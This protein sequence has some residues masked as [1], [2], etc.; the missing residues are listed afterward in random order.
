M[1]STGNLVLYKGKPCVVIDS[2]DRAEIRLPDGSTTRIR[3]K[4][5][6]LLH[7]GP[8][9][10]FDGNDIPQGDFETARQVS[11]GETVTLKELSELVFGEFLPRTAWAS[12]REILAGERFKLEDGAARA[13]T[14]EE[15]LAVRRKAAEKAEA[16][17][18]RA[19]FIA[20]G[21][22]FV[23][24]SGDAPFV[25]EI[26]AFALGSSKKGQLL[27]EIGFAET[28]EAAHEF[29]L[30]IG[31]WGEF[32][33]PHPARFGM[34]K[35]PPAV[36]IGPRDDE[37]RVD[38]TGL[39]SWAI[40]NAWTHDPDDAVAIEGK[41]LWI[42]AADPASS[43]AP[44]SPADL[45]ALARGATLYDPA[46]IVPMFPEA[47]LSSFCL[48]LTEISPALSFRVLLAN[49]GSIEET[50]ALRSWIKVRR[51]SYNEADLRLDREP[52]AALDAIA[53]RNEERRTAAGAVSIDIPEVRVFVVDGKPRIDPVPDT[54]SSSIV[55]EMMLIG[56]E[57]VARY[58]Y[59]AKL[60]IP[61]YSQESPLD[62]EEKPG[63]AGQ[64]ALRRTMR[65]GSVSAIPGPHRGLGLTFY[66]QAFS[67]LRRYPDLLAHQQIRSL[68]AGRE[69]LSADEIV[70]RVGAAQAAMSQVRQAERASN[71]HWTLAYLKSREGWTDTGVVVGANDRSASVYIPS[72]GLET[73]VRLPR[74]ELN[75]QIELQLTAIDLPKLEANFD[76]VGESR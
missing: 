30:R 43:V 39:D 76:V 37:G 70:R 28:P 55:R 66:S 74:A 69:P 68:L 47:A 9:K 19:E 58:S 20:R 32:Y 14:D 29:L 65:P 6:E 73:R 7:V 36:E 15:S 27:K 54:R 63:L 59:E 24:E 3:E 67:P 62:S 12:M 45:E 60:P 57:A 23:V 64:F 2:G 21:R 41:Y 44:E 72:I 75:D 17:K 35:R 61:Y 10:S 34:P 49:D 4:D 48:G 71:L 56:G 42:H 1:F 33:N 46:L 25:S 51:L 5:A 53:R 26:E 40:D 22:R 13:L 8:V 31:T 38:L 18:A 16:G 11:A 52:F 50:V